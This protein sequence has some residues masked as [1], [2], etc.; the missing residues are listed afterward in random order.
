LGEL[1]IDGMIRVKWS[2]EEYAMMVFI[3]FLLFRIMTGDMLL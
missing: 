3:T 2:L 1:G